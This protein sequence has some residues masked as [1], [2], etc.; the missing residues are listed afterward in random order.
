VG[1]PAFDVLPPAFELP[2]VAAP[3]QAE[4]AIRNKRMPSSHPLDV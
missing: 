2:G 4:H 3:E 1:A